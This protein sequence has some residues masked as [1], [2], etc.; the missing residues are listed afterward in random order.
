MT[1]VECTNC[2]TGGDVAAVESAVDA[3]GT[4]VQA[5]ATQVAAL[6]AQVQTQGQWIQGTTELLYFA[7][8][9][10][11]ILGVALLVYTVGRWFVLR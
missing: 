4:S 10:A 1:Q 9:A 7:L 11:A 6:S 5:V 8:V 3:V 2:A